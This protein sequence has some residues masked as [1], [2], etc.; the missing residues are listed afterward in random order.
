M[1]ECMSFTK[2]IR[3]HQPSEMEDKSDVTLHSE[4]PD[5]FLITKEKK[6]HKVSECLYGCVLK[7]WFFG[8]RKI[9]IGFSPKMHLHLF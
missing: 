9:Q 6:K 4:I 3:K 8:K 1:I 5:L 2:T 7:V